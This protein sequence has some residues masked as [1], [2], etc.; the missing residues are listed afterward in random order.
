[1]SYVKVTKCT[2][3]QPRKNIQK[4]ALTFEDQRNMRHI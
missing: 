4:L 2:I 3:A 1:M